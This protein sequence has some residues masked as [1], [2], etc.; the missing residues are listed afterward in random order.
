MSN[1]LV[2]NTVSNNTTYTNNLVLL[3]KTILNINSITITTFDQVENAY[4]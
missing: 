1:L 2:S 4:V 3:G